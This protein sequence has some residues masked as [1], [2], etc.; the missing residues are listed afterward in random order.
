MIRKVFVDTSAW[1]A[2]VN[3]SDAAHQKAKKVRDALLKDHIQFVV[4]N[5]VMVEIANA[6][7]RIPHRETAV[8][9]I[10]FIEMTENI[11]IV[12]IDK[13][14]YK[15][16][17]RVY[18]TYLDKEWSLTDCTSFEVMRAR[19]ITEA[20]TTDKHFEQAGFDVLIKI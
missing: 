4:T 3:K 1:L 2:L 19:R 20:F 14:I 17:W 9:L 11:Q 18:S 12:E 5:Y 8:K 16:A 6:L 15:E 10:N 7:C 13:E